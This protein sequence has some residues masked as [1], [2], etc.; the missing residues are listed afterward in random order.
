MKE[1]FR[2]GPREQRAGPF[3]GECT[4]CSFQ[5]LM[6]SSVCRCLG[7]MHKHDGPQYWAKVCTLPAAGLYEGDLFDPG[8]QRGIA[9]RNCPPN[10][11]SADHL[12]SAQGRYIYIEFSDQRINYE[13]MCLG[14]LPSRTLWRTN[15]VLSLASNKA[16]HLVD[17]GRCGNNP[18][19]VRINGMH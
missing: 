14:F 19:G 13:G 12:V 1:T 2:R 3:S 16:N 8:F 4:T 18:G 9:G 10:L 17:K 11:G 15:E 6:Y 7:S 5:C